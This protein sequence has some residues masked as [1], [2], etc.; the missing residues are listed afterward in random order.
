MKLRNLT[1]ET[2]LRVVW[3]STKFYLFHTALTV[4][5]TRFLLSGRLQSIISKCDSLYILHVDH[6]RF[7]AMYIL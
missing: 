4:E 5:K 6:I 2:Q 3:V 1:K 7:C